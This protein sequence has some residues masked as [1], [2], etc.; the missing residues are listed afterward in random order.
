MHSCMDV[1]TNLLW[2]QFRGAFNTMGIIGAHPCQHQ[3]LAA[4]K[5]RSAA[6]IAGSRDF[7]SLLRCTYMLRHTFSAKLRICMSRHSR[8]VHNKAAHH[9][10]PS[11]P[12]LQVSM[13]I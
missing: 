6:P 9:G 7:A 5:Q 4:S 13:Y 12:C 8:K 1:I 2:H 11:Q 10:F 3:D